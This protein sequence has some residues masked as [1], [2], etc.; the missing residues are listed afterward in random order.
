MPEPA[1]DHRR[2]VAARNLEAILDAAEALL[3]R[4]ASASIAAVATEAGVSRVTVYAHFPTRERLLEAV[5]ERAVGR[6]SR[7]LHAAEPDRGAPLDALERVIAA[8]WSELGRNTAIAQ[9]AS[10]QLSPAAMSR[11]HDA[12]QR[13]LRALVD[14]G[15][16]EGAFRTDVPAGWLVT[17]TFALLHACGDDVRAGRLDATEALEV[18]TSTL[19]RVLAA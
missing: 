11:S 2:A 7:S 16:A 13:E 4:R 1:T 5:V 9:A 12:A 3:E 6:A 18:L 17:S 10:E 14:R 15:R 8:G 19:R